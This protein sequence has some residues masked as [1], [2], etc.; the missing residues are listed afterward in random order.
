[1]AS[2]VPS[3]T[4]I[5]Q[6]P[7]TP[8][9]EMMRER[10]GATLVNTGRSPMSLFLGK[11]EVM[12]LTLSPVLPRQIARANSVTVPVRTYGRMWQP[13][14]LGSTK[15]SPVTASSRPRRSDNAGVPHDDEKTVAATGDRS[16]LGVAVSGFH[17]K[18]GTTVTAPVETTQIAP[19]IV[20]AAR[21]EPDGAAR[22]GTPRMQGSF[23]PRGRAFRRA[24]TNRM[25]R[26][27]GIALRRR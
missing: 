12:S 27:R 21:A 5:V 2:R 17:S 23:G 25:E 4:G 7:I 11:E 24:P 8:V 26:V 14:S 15:R 18:H 16:A 20:G 1:M 10:P 13:V 6:S 22:V 9:A 3:A 19:T